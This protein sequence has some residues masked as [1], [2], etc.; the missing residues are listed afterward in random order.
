MQ[1]QAYITN[2]SVFFPNKPV[3]ND[4]IESH[5]GVV[6][7][8]PSLARR[9]V[10]RNNGI[11][12]RYYA[13]DKEGNATHTSAQMAALAIEK[14]LADRLTVNDI[15][16]LTCGTASPEQLMPS[17]AV[18]VHGLLKGR[19]MEAVSFSGSCCTGMQALKYAFMSVQAGFT[20]NA[21]CAASERLSPWMR[22][23][24]FQKEAKSLEALENNPMLA[25]EKDFLRWMLSDGAAAVL[26][27]AEKPAN[28][29]LRIDWIE[30][31]SYANEKEV[32][33]YAGGEKN[34]EGELVGWTLFPTDEWLT[35]SLFALKQD[36]RMLG[37]N[38]VELGGRFLQQIVQKRSFN[39]NEVDWFLPHLSSMF[40]KEKTAEEMT[41]IGLHIPD[42][43]WFVN[44]P[45]VGNVGS[46]SAFIML[47]ELFSSGRLKQ[48]EKILIM[49]PESA[50]FSYTYCLLTVC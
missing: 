21:V 18:Q 9:I 4:E 27:Q 26:V 7:G 1:K 44:L 24:Y 13:L 34:E 19:N 20:A 38:I 16:L 6:N 36:T 12:N 50:R 40:F 15:E 17:H 42:E 46:A 11:K 23:E 41:R 48:G 39:V 45:N 28:T 43:K 22:A 29:S 31:C 14:L 35:K 8:K 33:M 37:S 47:E 10:L 30:N 2:L 25:F 49:V 3:H 5:L 32:C